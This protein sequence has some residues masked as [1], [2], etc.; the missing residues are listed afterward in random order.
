ME[1]HESLKNCR[2]SFLDSISKKQGL[3]QCLNE[4]PILNKA[5]R[6][7]EIISGWNRE[8]ACNICK[9]SWFDHNDATRGPNI[10]VCQRCQN[11]KEKE[12]PM[13]SKINR[14]I[15][16]P[17]PDCFKDLN[18]IE[19]GAIRLIIPYIT[20]F[21]N[22]AAHSI[23]F[24]Q[25]IAGFA[26]RLPKILPRPIKDLQ[27]ILID[28]SKGKMREFKANVAEIAAALEWLITHSEDYRDIK[29]SE[30]NLSQYP[31]N[32]K[33]ELPTVNEAVDETDKKSK[34]VND[35][36]TEG[37]NTEK[38]PFENDDE[39]LNKAYEEYNTL[40]VI[41]KLSKINSWSEIDIKI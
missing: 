1:D 39:N 29:I 21:K 19:M 11:D 13:F 16:G 14:M 20:M 6:I 9:E 40:L 5:T 23:S 32:G 38:H 17:H 37:T 18:K 26:K 35:T 22:K 12:I 25:D 30:E 8:E 33:I 15:P 10:G 3:S 7:R 24:Y 28:T 4:N 36:I 34:T 31:S 27:I 41:K 2:K